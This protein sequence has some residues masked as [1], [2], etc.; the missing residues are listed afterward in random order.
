MAYGF[1]R[2]PSLWRLAGAA[3]MG[4]PPP[5]EYLELLKKMYGVEE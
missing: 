3:E 5:A 2:A 1:V 4:L